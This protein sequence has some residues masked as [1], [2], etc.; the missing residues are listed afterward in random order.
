MNDENKNDSKTSQESKS[1][2]LIE[3]IDL[4]PGFYSCLY[5][6]ET[7]LKTSKSL[8]ASGDYQTSIPIATIAIEESMKGLELLKKFRHNQVVTVE[9]WND[10]KNHKHKLTHG[11]EEAMEDLRNATEDDIKKAKEEVVKTSQ[12]DWGG[13]IDDVLKNLQ[14]K[15]SIYSHFQEL[16]EGC[17]YSDWDKLREKWIVFDE[18]SKDMQEA[19]AFFVFIETQTTLN[20]LKVAIERYVN[21]LRENKQLLK[22]LPYPSYAELRTP[23]KWDSNNLDHPIQSKVDQV[24]YEKGSK[25]MRQFIDEKSFQFLSFGIFRKTMHK[26]LKVIAKQE[27]EKRFPHPMIKAMVMAVSAAKN[28]NK[29]G[30]KIVVANDQEQTYEGKPMIAFRIVVNMD[31]DVRESIKITD[32]AHPEIEFTQDMIEKIIRTETIIEQNPGK[33]I[34]PNIW[35]EALSVIGIRTKMIKL[36]EISD[37]IRNAKEMTRSEN[38][39][40]IS[41]HMIDQINAIKGVEEWNSL[42][43]TLR[44]IMTSCYGIKKYPEYN[45]HIT[46]S[47]NIRKFKCRQTILYIL[48]K[49]YL[50]TA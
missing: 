16:R 41:Q 42:D 43:T 35:I 37:V 29:E 10:L 9:D 11:M 14:S 36:E 8:F 20:L 15:V 45:V 31:L 48:E 19:L 23:E 30:K 28:K 22:K 18:L 1:K 7:F 21:K 38:C 32:L 25:V 3:N 12:F 13:S 44:T 40:G 39:T 4:L 5:N 27:N 34:P 24:K 49:P 47:V 17:F 26:Y 33:E 2:I 6:S 46:P 50:P